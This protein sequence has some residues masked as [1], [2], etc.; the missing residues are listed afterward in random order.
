LTK[1]F[2]I[3]RSNILRCVG[4]KYIRSSRY[5]GAFLTHVMNTSVPTKDLLRHN[6]WNLAEG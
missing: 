6:T 2:F 5:K 1:G 3:K 4:Y